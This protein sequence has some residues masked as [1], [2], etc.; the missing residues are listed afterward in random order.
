MVTCQVRPQASVPIPWRPRPSNSDGISVPP[1][2]QSDPDFR[3]LH[4]L[5]CIGVA[6]EDR[7][8]TAAGTARQETIARLRNLSVQGLVELASGPFGGWGLTDDGRTA[9]Q[10]LVRLELDLTDARDQVHNC[11]QSFKKLNPDLLQV[12]SDW[13][14]R[15]VG[16]YPI[17]NDHI[18]SDYDA[19]VLSRLMR[20]DDAAQPVCDELAN[21]LSRFGVYGARLSGALER[22]LTGQTDYV[23]DSLESYHA[24]WFQL[25]EDLLVTL[26]ISRDDER[27]DSGGAG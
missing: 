5:R 15:R 21:R 19:N 22:A 7:V 14:M 24:V 20:V 12:C 8:A 17:L 3:V 6:S 26:G 18:D 9:Q 25:H 4:T 11:Y 23:A 16:Q 27:R 2:H 10:A 13:Q 1:T